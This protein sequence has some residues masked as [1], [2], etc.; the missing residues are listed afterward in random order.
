[1]PDDVEAVNWMPDGAGG[2]RRDPARGF[3]TVRRISTRPLPPGTAA[4]LEVA[5]RLGAPFD[6]V[7]VD[8]CHDGRAWWLGEMTVYN[9]SGLVRDIGHDPQAQMTRAWDLRR[10]WFLSQARLTG[11]RALYARTLRRALDR[12]AGS[13]PPLPPA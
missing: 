9:L 2:W 3:R 13:A 11:W 8:L 4:G 5:R 1:M 7:R 10:S 6:H 12:E